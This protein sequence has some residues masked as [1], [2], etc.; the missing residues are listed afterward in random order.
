[1]NLNFGKSLHEVIFSISRGYKDTEGVF[2]W[3][4]NPSIRSHR[5]YLIALIYLNLQLNLRMIFW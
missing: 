5:A 2:G 1:M 3:G 4:V